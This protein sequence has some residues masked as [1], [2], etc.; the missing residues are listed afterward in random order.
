MQANRIGRRGS[1]LLVL[2]CIAALGGCAGSQKDPAYATPGDEP[3]PSE[4][5]DQRSLGAP[6]GTR[7]ESGD[8][9]VAPPTTSGPEAEML[10]SDSLEESEADSRDR[11]MREVVEGPQTARGRAADNSAQNER[12]RIG[13]NVVTSL[14]QDNEKRDIELVASIRR[15]IVDDDSLS[16]DAK[17][18][19]IVAEGGEV[20]LRGP[21]ANADEKSRVQ[22]LARQAG[23]E[24]VISLIEVAK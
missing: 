11:D 16:F 19:K 22:K 15:A 7:T 9:T 5:M 24:R 13:G 18:I 23:A 21:V 3:A 14:S 4:Q 2:G 12:D 17:N 8:M 6:D 1:P 10:Q 20:T